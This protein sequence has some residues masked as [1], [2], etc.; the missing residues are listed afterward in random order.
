MKTESDI[1]VLLFHL[2]E[3]WKRELL[4]NTVDE[5]LKLEASDSND[6][7]TLIGLQF[8]ETIE[9][10]GRQT[11]AGQAY[12]FGSS[13]IISPKFEEG[14]TS[15]CFSDTHGRT[16]KV[17]IRKFDSDNNEI[18]IVWNEK[19]EDSGVE[20]EG[21]SALT[22]DNWFDPDTK[23]P[24][25]INLVKEFIENPQSDNVS[26]SLLKRETPGL[27]INL[28]DSKL[29]NLKKA[30]VA[31]NNSYLA[32]QGPPGTG[33]TWTGAH[34]IHH[35]ITVEKKRVGITAQ[36]KEAIRNLLEATIKVFEDKKELNLLNAVSKFNTNIPH[37]EYKKSWKNER[38]IT[39]DFN[40]LASTTWLWADEKFSEDFT[41]F[42]YLVIDEAGQLSLIDALVAA[43]GANNLLLL[44]DPQQ[45]SQVTQAS[46]PFETGASVFEYLLD[47]EDTIS[48]EMGAFLNKTFRMR[49]EICKFISEEFYDKRL[50]HD[51]RCEKREIGNGVNGLQWLPVNHKED[52]VN[53]SEEEATVIT[54]IV[55]ELLGSRWTK[56]TKEENKY[57]TK[58]D[59]LSVEDFMVVAPYNAQV[60]EIQSQLV[61]AEIAGIDKDTVKRIVGTVDK[62]QGREAPVVLYSLTTSR[63]DLIPKGRKTDFIFSP[64]RLNVAISRAQCLTFLIG[65]EELID[66]RATSID[67][68][69]DLN[70]F[71]RYI[72]EAQIPSTED[73]SIFMKE[74]EKIIN[75]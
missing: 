39:G 51:E 47:G 48:E 24:T 15:V 16:T 42:D 27:S 68:M 43:N 12:T 7:D 54:E 74:A 18:V 62:F 32:I 63:Q 21:I 31:L 46:H 38:L 49:P 73:E 13:Q 40:L 4:K 75:Y 22:L 50:N 20:P 52:C 3:Y 34:I 6:P 35:L 71:C 45:L 30:A 41:K 64:N 69:K 28:K 57:T 25:L 58:E 53:R 65:T 2:L 70:H 60:R 1:Y 11:L 17:S 61:D 67:E 56:V 72:S 37:V 23:R 19:A 55:G 29:E 66:T 9:A 44:G 5:Q 26:F 8:K 59:T 33:K 10:V 36:S 14:N